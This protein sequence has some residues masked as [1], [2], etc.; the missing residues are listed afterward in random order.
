M[1]AYLVR[2]GEVILNPII[3]LMFMAAVLY[4]CWGLFIFIANA[5]DDTKRTEGK[6]HMIWAF[7]G[8]LI[9]VMAWGI[10]GGVEATINEIK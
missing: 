4:F 5:D 2:I 7:V 6:S 8:M 3:Q 9:M 10:L 1:Q